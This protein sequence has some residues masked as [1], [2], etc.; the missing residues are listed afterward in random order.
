MAR[1]TNQQRMFETQRQTGKHRHEGTAQQLRHRICTT[2]AV[3]TG[4]RACGVQPLCANAGELARKAFTHEPPRQAQAAAP[5]TSRRGAEICAV[6]DNFARH[7][8]VN[9]PGSMNSK[10]CEPRV[11]TAESSRTPDSRYRAV[12]SC[13]NVAAFL[14]V[15]HKRLERRFFTVKPCDRT[16]NTHPFTV[17]PCDRTP[18]L[19]TVP[20]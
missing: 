5:S 17:K 4:L 20:V 2:G 8:L 1:C 13:G 10:D 7:L 9:V 19:H 16:P 15:S 11:H 3:D 18:T 12:W 6:K 14:H